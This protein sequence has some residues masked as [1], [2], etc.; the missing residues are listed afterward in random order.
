MSKFC[1]RVEMTFNQLPFLERLKKVKDVGISAFKFWGWSN[2]DVDAI[3]KKKRELGLTA[4]SFMV[5][6]LGDDPYT[7][8]P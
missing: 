3:A 6:P 5:D 1:V 8:L 4:S 7:G 2:K